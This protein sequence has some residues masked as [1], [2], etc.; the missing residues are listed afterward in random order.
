ME[1]MVRIDPNGAQALLSHED[2][3]DDLVVYGQDGF[4]KRIEG[5]NL[6]LAQA[7]TQSFDG[8]RA[9]I[10]DLQ[11]KVTEGSIAEA[12]GLPQEGDRWFKNLKLEGMP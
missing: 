4:I 11:L 10:G 8:T 7:F 3:M 6:K 1:P 12:T 5:F 9:K 2:S